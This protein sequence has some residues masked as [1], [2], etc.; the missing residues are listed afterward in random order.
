MRRDAREVVVVA[1]KL[2]RLAD[3]RIDRAFRELGSA[4]RLGN[5]AGEQRADSN[6][7]LR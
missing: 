7:E 1:R 5:R 3:S 4:E 6:L 2:H